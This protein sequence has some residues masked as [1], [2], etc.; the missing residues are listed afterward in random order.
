MAFTCSNQVKKTPLETGKTY[1]KLTIKTSGRSLVLLL[2]TLKMICTYSSV[3][4]TE[5]EQINVGWVWET[6]VSD[7][8]LIFN[9]CEKSIFLWAE[10][11][12]WAT[13]FYPCLLKIWMQKDNF[14]RQCFKKINQTLI[15][16][17]VCVKKQ[18]FYSLKTQQHMIIL[19]NQYAQTSN[20]L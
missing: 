2:L 6:I 10:K 14:S 4:I 7:N 15:Y 19:K 5:L 20:Y 13:R 8:K 1:S 18:Q 3:I 12:C 9:N 11:I 17:H 16:I